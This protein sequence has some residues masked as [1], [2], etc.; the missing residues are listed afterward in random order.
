MILFNDASLHG[1]FPAFGP[2]N[3]SMRTL[4][5]IRKALVGK[6]LQLRVCRTVRTRQVTSEQTFNDFLGTIPQQLKTRLLLWLDREGPFWDDERRHSDGEYFECAGELVT[7]TGAAEAAYIQSEGMPT[8]LFS[9]DPSKFLSDPL[10]VA[11]RGR[12]CGDL[13]VEISNGWTLDHVE[14]CA[15]AFEQP[16]SSWNE[17]LEW[18]ERECGNLI[19]S[20]EI[21]TQLSMPFHSNVA[22]RSKVLLRVLDQIVG[23]MKTGK[24]KE[25]EEIRKEWMHGERARFSPSSDSELRNFANELTFSYP[26]SGRRVLCSWHG[27]IQTPQF[28]IHYEWPLPEGEERLL[29]AYI[30]PKITKR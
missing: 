19:L 2:F 12:E 30:G 20:P 17:L 13:H 22:Q 7:D 5:E 6:G 24:V 15:N 18:A 3:E 23:L 28:R 21:R 4:W 25:V 16:F 29:V 10:S 14:R 11:W 8:W 1:Q 9:L 26:E 27:K